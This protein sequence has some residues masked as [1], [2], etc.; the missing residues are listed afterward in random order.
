MYAILL[1]LHMENIRDE[2]NFMKNFFFFFF[3]VSSPKWVI[4]SCEQATKKEDD[5]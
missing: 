3:L 2:Q 5:T 4:K 1:S